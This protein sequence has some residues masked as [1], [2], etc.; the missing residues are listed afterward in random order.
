MSDHPWLDSDSGVCLRENMR[1]QTSLFFPGML[2]LAIGCS[3]PKPPEIHAERAEVIDDDPAGM[4]VRVHASGHN[5]NAGT[6]AVRSARGKVY[7]ES[8]D[9]GEA[10]VTSSSSLSPNGKSPVVLEA[11]VP[12]K[13][14]AYA[15]GKARPE[16]VVHYRFVGHATFEAGERLIDLPVEQTGE[17]QKKKVFLAAIR[18]IGLPKS[19]SPG[20]RLRVEPVGSSTGAGK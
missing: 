12:W 2:V 14:V 9:T 3:Q 16:D 5:P 7:V 1:W 15:V 17:V 8:I 13:R 11:K 18:H 10:T 4:V 6:V 19:L 20:G